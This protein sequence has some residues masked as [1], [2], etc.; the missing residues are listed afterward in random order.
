ESAVAHRPDR[1]HTRAENNPVRTFA[2]H[3]RAAHP[4]PGDPHP[5]ATGAR[6]ARSPHRGSC[7]GGGPPADVRATT[8]LRPTPPTRRSRRP[9]KVSSG[10]TGFRERCCKA[11]LL[12][13]R[14]LHQPRQKSP[15][16]SGRRGSGFALLVLE[17]EEGS[18]S[19]AASG[20]GRCC[21]PFLRR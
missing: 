13:A 16:P 8:P 15:R 21:C 19:A 18:Y 3:V 4:A 6:A 7:R 9:R 11:S 14:V 2:S 20:P 12:V 10:C 1:Q 5:A 17:E